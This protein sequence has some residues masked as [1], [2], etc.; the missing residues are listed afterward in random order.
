MDPI[1]I[2]FPEEFETERLLVRAARP[3]DGEAVHKAVFHSINELKPWLPFAQKEESEKE[4]EANVRHSYLRFLARED[5]RYHVFLKNSGE[6]VASTGLHRLDW[7]VRRFEIGYWIDTRHSGKGYM[8][9]A[10]EGLTAFAFDK[11]AAN[12]VEIR[13]DA[14][15]HSSRAIPER[16]GFELEGILKNEDL[17]VDGSQ[18]RD[19]CIY[20]KVRQ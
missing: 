9:E 5:L 13:C 17:S 11:L 8:T 10:V 3:G 20:S 12:R 16:L 2:D 7:K 1:M 14:K 19:S 6:F 15:N 4:R 18:L